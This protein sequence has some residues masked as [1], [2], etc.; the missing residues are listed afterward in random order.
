[1][2]NALLGNKIIARKH[3]KAEWVT[4]FLLPFND[5]TPA[6]RSRMRAISGKMNQWGL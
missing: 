2:P 5:K 3:L 1:M 6:V 4:L